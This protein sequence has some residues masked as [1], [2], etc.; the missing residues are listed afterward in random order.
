MGSKC[1][2]NKRFTRPD[3]GETIPGELKVAPVE[4]DRNVQL[5]DEGEDRRVGIGNRTVRGAYSDWIERYQNY[6]IGRSALR[7]IAP[8][9][10][11]ASSLGRVSG[12]NRVDR[13]GSV[14]HGGRYVAPIR[15]ISSYRVMV[16]ASA[17]F[18]AGVGPRAARADP[19]AGQGG[20]E[21]ASRDDGWGDG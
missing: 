4:I 18:L 19:R 17:L 13:R 6:R 14:C 9:P 20:A 15:P 21:H 5:V 10:N 8:T 11:A 1:L 12:P 2:L 3:G 7:W 16:N